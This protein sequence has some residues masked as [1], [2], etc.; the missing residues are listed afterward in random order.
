MSLVDFFAHSDGQQWM[1]EAACAG[2]GSEE[3]FP[4]ESDGETAV[5]AIKVCTDCIVQDECL[6]YALR[7]ADVGVWGAMSERQR[8]LHKK[9]LSH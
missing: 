3:F 7:H 4:D 6:Q 2:R 5:P 1:L 8:K 9:E